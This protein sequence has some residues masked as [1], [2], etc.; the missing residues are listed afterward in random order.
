M[1]ASGW[2]LQKEFPPTSIEVAGR[3]LLFRAYDF[4]AGRRS[5]FVFF[6]VREDATAGT[7]G[8][9]MRETH[10]ARWRAAWE[11]NRGLGQRVIEIAIFGASNLAE[12]ETSLRQELPKLIHIQS[13]PL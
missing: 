2:Q 1:P 4:S 6:F 3:P 12:A 11:G 13:R 8:G 7:L 9:N 5:V 10:S